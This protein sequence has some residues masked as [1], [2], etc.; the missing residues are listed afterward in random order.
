[1]SSEGAPRAKEI[2]APAA[3]AGAYPALGPSTS[4]VMRP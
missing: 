2:G 3:M 4:S 1:M